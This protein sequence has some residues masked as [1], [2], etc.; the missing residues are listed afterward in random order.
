MSTESIFTHAIIPVKQWVVPRSKGPRTV[1]QILLVC[2]D[3]Q[4]QL[5]YGF[6]GG[7]QVAQDSKR[8]L[9]FGAKLSIWSEKENSL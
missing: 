4:C 8:G 7:L 5:G 3:A 6:L 2:L 9:L 1:R